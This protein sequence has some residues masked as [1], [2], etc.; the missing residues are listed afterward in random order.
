MSST[1][2]NLDF[3]NIA[4]SDAKEVKFPVQINGD[5]RVFFVESAYDKMKQHTATTSE[6]ELCGVLIGDV[7][8]DALGFYLKIDAVIEGKD[9]NNYGAQVTFTHQTWEHINAIKDKQYANQRIV[10]W[11]HTHPGFGVFLS[12]MDMFIQ[13]NTFNHPYQVAIVVETKQNVEGCFAWV[14]GKSVPLNR[15]WVGE[16]EI[17]LATGPVEKFKMDSLAGSTPVP[18]GERSDRERDSENPP[19]RGGDG[20]PIMLVTLLAFLLCGY[21]LGRQMEA[22][23]LRENGIEALESELYSILEFTAVN[24]AALKDLSDVDAKLAAI[25]DKLKKNDAAGADANLKELSAQ[26]QKMSAIYGQKR[27]MFRE[28][29]ADFAARKQNLSERVNSVSQH[30]AGVDEAVA[31]LYFLR[32]TDLVT[33]NGVPVDPATLSTADIQ[34]LKDRID[35]AVMLAPGIKSIIEEK[36]P[37]ILDALYPGRNPPAQP[38]SAAPGSQAAPAK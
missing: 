23:N 12:G 28:K 10:G 3:R 13:E 30:Q 9:A 5:Y 17:A 20:G 35:K 14:G 34:E 2:N 1:S 16:K 29:I 22:R 24:A 18:K 25:D 26:V 15:Y 7:C 27:S 11:Y 4:K 19:N 33:K 31:N 32:I 37:K 8:R 38:Q 21:L 6:V 36:F